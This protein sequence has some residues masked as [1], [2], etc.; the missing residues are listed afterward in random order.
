[1][2]HLNSFQ[3]W[4][5]DYGRAFGFIVTPCGNWVKLARDGIEAEC[6][7]AQ[8]VQQACEAWQDFVLHN[9]K[10]ERNV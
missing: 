1:L 7:G 5:S 3:K 2:E 9:G 4:A 6:M 10:W 8:G